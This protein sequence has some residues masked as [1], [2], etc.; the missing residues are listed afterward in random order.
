MVWAS[1]RGNS[2]GTKPWWFAILGSLILVSYGFIPCLQ[3]TDGFGRIYAIYGGYFIVLS[4]LLSWGLDGN[5]PDLGDVVGGSIA[6]V[7][8]FVIMLWPRE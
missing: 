1:I 3:P 5:K 8:A 4:F 2:K 7:G 6:I